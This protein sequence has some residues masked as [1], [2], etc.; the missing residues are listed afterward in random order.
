MAEISV[1]TKPIPT[2]ITKISRLIMFPEIVGIAT[3]YVRAWR[4]GGRSSNPGK[5]GKVHFSISP[6]LSVGPAQL[7]IQWIRG[8][9][10]GGKT[11]AA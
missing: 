7:P 4:P 11:T 1:P 6:R 2:T 3:G 10:P 9:I 8:L 5:V